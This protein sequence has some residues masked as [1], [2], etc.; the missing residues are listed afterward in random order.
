MVEPSFAERMVIKHSEYLTNVQIVASTATNVTDTEV[1]TADG[2]SFSYDYLVVATGHKDSF[3]R[4]RAERL[5]QYEAG[6]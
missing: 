5:G 3:P 2:H 6:Q 4:T 1:F